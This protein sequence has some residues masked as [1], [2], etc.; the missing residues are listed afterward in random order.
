MLA[1][2]LVREKKPETIQKAIDVALES[3][4]K[5]ASAAGVLLEKKGA[6]FKLKHYCEGTLLAG[7]HT[8][9]FVHTPLA[10]LR[11]LDFVKEVYSKKVPDPLILIITQNP[12]TLALSAVGSP[13]A[14]IVRF[15][16][17][18]MARNPW[19]QHFSQLDSPLLQGGPVVSRRYIDLNFR[20]V[21]MHDHLSFV[22]ELS[23]LNAA[24]P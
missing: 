23:K 18:P 2:E 19:N 21:P 9:G 3:M 17:P 16:G 14:E 4:V 24:A 1:Y 13:S 6:I 7:K 5:V 8:D 20:E 10:Q 22:I 15:D 11:L 12:H